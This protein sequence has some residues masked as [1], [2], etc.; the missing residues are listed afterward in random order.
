M[1]WKNKLIHISSGL[2]GGLRKCAHF[3][4]LG[5]VLLV[6]MIFVACTP[7]P[8]SIPVL[9]E[10]VDLAKLAGE[11]GGDYNNSAGRSGIITFTLSAGKDTAS[12][13]VMMF[14]AGSQ[15]PYLPPDYPQGMGTIGRHSQALKI[16][17]VRVAGL[18]VSGTLEPYVDPDCGCVLATTFQ[19]RLDQDLIEGTFVSRIVNGER[20]YTGRWKVIRKKI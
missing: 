15:Q 7:P 4:V 14:P 19:G 6:A 13:D 20:V 1:K 3:R 5:M 11:W 17:F 18:N 16:R 2:I 10:S 12:G 9:A 8:P